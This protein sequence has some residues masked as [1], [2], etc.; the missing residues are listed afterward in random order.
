MQTTPPP[1]AFIPSANT[2]A[3]PAP[4]NRSATAARPLLRAAFYG[5]TNSPYLGHAGKIIA[6]Q[7][8][9]CGSAC[10]GRAEL[11]RYFYD[12]PQAIDR[13]ELHRIPP[14]LHG[15]SEYYGGWQDL[16]A[17]L[18]KEGRDFDVVV[19]SSIDRISRQAR[20]FKERVLPLI[21]CRVS[22]VCAQDGWHENTPPLWSLSF[23]PEIEIPASERCLPASKRCSA[24][25]EITD[26][27]EGGA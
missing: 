27:P 12:I 3:A 11:V 14:F 26:N 17:T 7:F 18:P 22:I 9:I 23:L 5:R 15:P 13:T 10:S 1:Q 16:V 19:C 6:Q 24:G 8:Q 20:L 25:L 2:N 4:T 21:S